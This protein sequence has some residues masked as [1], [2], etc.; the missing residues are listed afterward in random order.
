VWPTYALQYILEPLHEH[1]VSLP[2][3]PPLESHKAPYEM[4]SPYSN[5]LQVATLAVHR[6]SILTKS[7]LAA[8]DK[9]TIDK[10]DASPVTIA[11]FAAQ[12]LIISAIRQH[13]P[14]DSFVAEE[15]A[16][17]LRDDSNLLSRV[18]GLVSTPWH[19]GSSEDALAV[20][21]TKEEMLDII[22]IGGNGSGGKSGRVWMI[23]PIDGT[24]TFMR[25]EQYVVCLALVDHGVQKVGVLGCPNLL[26]DA[27]KLREDLVDK[28]DYG[29]MLSAVE[30]QGASIRA[31][32]RNG[33]QAPAVLIKRS[34]AVEPK[35]LCWVESLQSFS[36]LPEKHRR[37]ASALGSTWPVL[38]LWSMQMKYVALA[39]GACDVMIRIPSKQD[40][41]PY[42]W[43][44]A[45]GQ[46]IF[47]ET[48]GK[49]TDLDGKPFDFGKGR[50]LG[51]TDGWVVAIPHVHR[52]VLEAV[53]QVRT[54]TK[55]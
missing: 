6:A 25:G 12:A 35:D 22:D 16:T 30:G 11:D 7:L 31:M 10:S 5:E 47:Q 27:G 51:K 14:D 2:L 33:L 9:G 38:D 36:F 1:L 8:T 41:R 49:V 37:V 21:A 54:D 3:Q 15:S 13:F 26:L 34:E 23:D 55:S 48:G 53:N 4:D 52:Q 44:H 18:W 50:T 29:L 32:Y 43:D 17:A 19:M 24:A 39:V 45:G 46:L 20:P 40:Y 28:K 42:V